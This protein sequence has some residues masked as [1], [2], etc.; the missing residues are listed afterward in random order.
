[1]WV[2]LFVKICLSERRE[3]GRRYYADPTADVAIAH[4]MKEQKEK[5][6]TKKRK[7]SRT[8]NKKSS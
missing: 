8:N 1:M 2:K 4:V 6:Q 5:K 3:M 7:S